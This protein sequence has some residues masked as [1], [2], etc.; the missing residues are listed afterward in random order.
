MPFPEINCR[1]LW[2][3]HMRF[4]DARKAGKRAIFRAEGDIVVGLRHDRWL[5]SDRIAQHAEAVLGANHESVESIE[6]VK[7]MLQRIAEA[8]ALADAPGEIA[9]G[10]LR[11]IVRLEAQ[12]VAL[13]LPAKRIVIGQRS[14]MH[15]ALIAASGEWMGAVGSDGGLC[16]HPGVSNAV[17]PGH[18]FQM[19]A[20]GH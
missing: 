16:G 17:R 6:I 19:E 2:L 11:V 1:G 9:R 10:H 12:A 8:V 13:E 5:A 3:P 7:R 20:L 4:L 14:V 18:L 15:E